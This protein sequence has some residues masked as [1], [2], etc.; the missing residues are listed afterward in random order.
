[1]IILLDNVL[2]SSIPI[3]ITFIIRVN[4]EIVDLIFFSPKMLKNV[5]SHYPKLEKLKSKI[6][7]IIFLI[8]K[9]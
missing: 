5:S 7:S 6:A 8:C 1:M 2:V 9:S 3:L 4:L